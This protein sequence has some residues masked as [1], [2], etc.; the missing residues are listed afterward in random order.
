VLSEFTV[1]GP[2]SA[3]GQFQTTVRIFVDVRRIEMHTEILNNDAV[4]RYRV[5][6]PTTIAHGTNTHEIPFGALQRPEGI[7]FP[8]QNW[9]DYSSEAHG[10]T[11][12][13]RGLPGN[14]VAEGTLL[15]SLLRSTSI[16][17][18]GFQGGYGPGM[19]SDSGLELGK[20][21]TFDYVLL[22]HTGDWRHDAPWRQGQAFNQPL[23]ACT[24]EQHPGPL[25]ACWGFLTVSHPNIQLST[26]K[27][28]ENR[29]VVLR[30]Y[31]AAGLSTD[32]VTISLPAAC[33]SATE[34]NLLED[35]LQ[36]LEI[37]DGKLRVNMRAFEI[38]TIGIER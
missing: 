18:Y 16:V 30:L 4:V 23:I 20:T 21:L 35:P 27:N 28:A 7:E 9:I 22:P 15:L 24:V 32:N 25:P 13:N 3:T 36:T 14:N 34:M 1:A 11:L 6:F 2:F 17:A 26:L 8:A 12:L 31:E 10:I 5:L 33:R 38:K 29:G 37:V 19:S